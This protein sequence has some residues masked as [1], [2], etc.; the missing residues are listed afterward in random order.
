M[1]TGSS[2]TGY[3]SRSNPSVKICM[4]TNETHTQ[5]QSPTKNMADPKYA[6]LLGFGTFCGILE[7]GLAICKTCNE[8][9]PNLNW[10]S[11]VNSGP[12]QYLA[13]TIR[14]SKNNLF[15][16]H[17]FREMSMGISAADLFC[18][19]QSVAAHPE[20]SGVLRLG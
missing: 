17:L 9:T 16:L 19:F 4:V 3:C 6:N 20:Y 11:P 7:I 10:T 15:G 18:G 12:A 8:L 2:M 1:L 14:S 13:N 5:I